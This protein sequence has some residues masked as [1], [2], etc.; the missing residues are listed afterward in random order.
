MILGTVIYEALHGDAA[1]AALV[2]TRITP[3]P[4]PQNQGLPAITYTPTGGDVAHAF[5][6]DPVIT[7]PRVQLDVWSM[8][9]SGAEAIARLMRTRLRNYRAVHTD[10]ESTITVQG[11]MVESEP[12]HLHEPDTQIHHLTFDVTF[13][14]VES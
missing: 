12:F 5:G 2:G 9:Y 13:H 11:T 10:S 14:Y 8:S 4:L 6:A 7:M 3:W 1:I